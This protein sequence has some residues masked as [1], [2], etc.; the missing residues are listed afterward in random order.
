MVHFHTSTPESMDFSSVLLILICIMFLNLSLLSD[1]LKSWF[2]C[3]V[4]VWFV[5]YDEINAIRTP[6]IYDISCWF[7]GI[8]IAFRMKI[9]GE[10]NR[11]MFKV[12]LSVIT[13]KMSADSFSCTK[14]YGFTLIAFISHRNI[15]ASYKTIHTTLNLCFLSLSIHH[16]MRNTKRCSVAKCVASLRSGSQYVQSKVGINGFFFVFVHHF[17]AIVYLRLRVNALSEFT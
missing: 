9:C 7:I 3:K 4:L 8:C 6:T 2:I 10:K 14:L 5:K 17:I 11:R 12:P 16:T 13:F 15:T 1:E